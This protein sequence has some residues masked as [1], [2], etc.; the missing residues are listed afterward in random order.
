MEL[1]HETKDFV[2]DV[3]GLYAYIKN[4]SPATE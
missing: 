1:L 2:T 4:P 3:K